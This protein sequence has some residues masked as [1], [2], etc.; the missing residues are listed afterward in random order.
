[1]AGCASYCDNPCTSLRG[2]PHIECGS[3]TTTT[4]RPGAV[5]FHPAAS[6]PAAA[7]RPPRC[8]VLKASLLVDRDALCVRLLHHSARVGP[9]ALRLLAA[10]GTRYSALPPTIAPRAEGA[11]AVQDGVVWGMQA[12]G[13][14]RRAIVPFSAS[15]SY[16]AECT[17]GG[18]H[19][20]RYE[21]NV[22][23]SLR[24]VGGGASFPGEHTLRVAT[25][26]AH[27]VGYSLEWTPCKLEAV[28]VLHDD[29]PSP[30]ALT[31]RVD[32]AMARS[33]RCAA[34][35]SPPE[36]PST[37]SI[38]LS[39]EPSAC[40]QMARSNAT[41]AV[42]IRYFLLQ[43]AAEVEF[44]A[45]AERTLCAGAPSEREYL[46]RLAALLAPV[47]MA[48]RLHMHMAFVAKSQCSHNTAV[49][50]QRAVEQTQLLQLPS[51][52]EGYFHLRR[53]PG[54]RLEWEEL[55]AGAVHGE[56]EAGRQTW[57]HL[58]APFTHEDNATVGGHALWKVASVD[59][60][61][62]PEQ[63]D[64]EADWCPLPILH[65]EP[66]N[67]RESYHVWNVTAALLRDGAAGCAAPAAARARRF[68][69]WRAALDEVMAAHRANNAFVVYYAAYEPPC[70]RLQALAAARATWWRPAVD[71]T[72]A[73][74]AR[75]ERGF[76]QQLEALRREGECS[77]AGVGA[78]DVTHAFGNDSALTLAMGKALLSRPASERHA[79]AA[80]ARLPRGR[81]AALREA[82]GA[83]P[84]E[85]RVAAGPFLSRWGAWSLTLATAYHKIVP[86]C[87]AADPL[88]RRLG[89]DAWD[90]TSQPLP[91]E[92]DGKIAYDLLPALRSAP[93]AL[94]LQAADAID[95]YRAFLHAFSP[96]RT[97]LVHAML[98][99]Q[100]PFD[101]DDAFLRQLLALRDA[102]PGVLAALR[103]AEGGL[104]AVCVVPSR[105]APSTAQSN[106]ERAVQMR[107]EQAAAQ[108]G[109]P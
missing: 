5:G 16:L 108:A 38:D 104:Q 50:R 66:Y 39:K 92:P 88:Y 61:F 8:G 76:T 68:A 62:L 80:C 46:S 96:F 72:A 27:G 11:W 65:H 86:V 20:E 63:P 102:L 100:C 9:L 34:T 57:L 58:M 44:L 1:M 69:A 87:A 89:P 6:A 49:D 43:Q 21:V 41:N 30:A 95:A 12:G 10:T 13:A 48:V 101:D 74:Q 32:A 26:P 19:A 14:E 91:S 90:C 51:Y 105:S 59:P 36:F 64:P 18:C 45:A 47:R 40:E 17:G 103:R 93:R 15:A 35:D 99:G 4:C 42:H 82:I 2:H 73:E 109:A 3:C 25:S 94:L 56:D 67:T 53:R 55:A 31:R 7:S 98:S 79:D 83:L 52:A 33:T 78:A 60:T 81:V 75:H 85:A 23:V 106:W 77:A 37:A 54:S 29:A 71:S 22:S 28:V 84:A 24:S 97:A 70:R 107:S